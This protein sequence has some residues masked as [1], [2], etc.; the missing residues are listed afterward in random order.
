MLSLLTL[1][2]YRVR[3]LFFIHSTADEVHHDRSILSIA[4]QPT[5]L[6]IFFDA[7]VRFSK[8]VLIVVYAWVNTSARVASCLMMM[9][10][11]LLSF[12]S[13][14]FEEIIYSIKFLSLFMPFVNHLTFAMLQTSKKQY[15]CDGCGIC[16]FV[17]VLLL[18]AH[19]FEP[20]WG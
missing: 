11:I 15:H 14:Q 5:L 3:V 18:L 6:N 4:F 13:Y 9:W 19:H 12:N 2:L 10:V 17:Y 7:V 1:A 20:F 16:R 8:F